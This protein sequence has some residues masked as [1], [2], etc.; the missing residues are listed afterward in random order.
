MYSDFLFSALLAA[1]VA[2]AEK[3]L[4]L[5]IPLYR[6]RHKNPFRFLNLASNLSLDPGSVPLCLFLRSL[7]PS[8]LCG[9]VEKWSSWGRTSDK[10]FPFFLPSKDGLFSVHLHGCFQAWAVVGSRYKLLILHFFLVFVIIYFF[11]MLSL[12]RTNWFATVPYWKFYSHIGFFQTFP[13]LKASGKQIM[14]CKEAFF[15]FFTLW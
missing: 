7:S 12:T 6:W 5:V 9:S 4:E 1:E 13:L 11:C 2:R 8:C 14:C 10:V 15:L 3:L